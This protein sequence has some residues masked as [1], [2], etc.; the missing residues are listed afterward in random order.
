MA[1]LTLD[2]PF[3]PLPSPCLPPRPCSPH[4]PHTRYA[5]FKPPCLNSSSA[6]TDDQAPGAGPC[7]GAAPHGQGQ[8][9]P[10][11]VGRRR[12]SPAC[13]T[14][15]C[16]AVPYEAGGT[17]VAATAGRRGP[18]GGGRPRRGW[19]STYAPPSGAADC[20]PAGFS[21]AKGARPRRCAPGGP[22]APAAVRGRQRRR[23]QGGRRRAGPPF[24]S[25]QW[26]GAG[27]VHRGR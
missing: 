4:V 8:H 15:D 16:G 14:A 26:V 22:H 23:R 21:T 7:V 2:G 20:T 9:A 11:Q 25:W 12:R 18:G 13:G 3:P 27:G 6:R 10:A 5:P 19:R 1:T 24:G 17:A